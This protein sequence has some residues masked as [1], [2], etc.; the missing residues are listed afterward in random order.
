MLVLGMFG[1][2]W[3]RRGEMSFHTHEEIETSTLV[4]EGA[5]EAGGTLTSTPSIFTNI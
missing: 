3:L 5:A 1:Q 4:Q 2:E